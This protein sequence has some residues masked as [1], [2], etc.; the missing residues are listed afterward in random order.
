MILRVR[1]RDG[2]LVPFR[3]EKITWAIYKAAAAVGGD[4]F[5]R[6]HAFPTRWSNT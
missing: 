6:A 5:A 2:Q 4:D 1:K 3:Q